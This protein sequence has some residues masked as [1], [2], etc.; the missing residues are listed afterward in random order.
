VLVVEPRPGYNHVVDLCDRAEPR[1]KIEAALNRWLGRPVVLRFL[2]PAGV[3]GPARTRHSATVARNDG[4]EDDPIVKLIVERF[5]A[6]LVRVDA[7]DE[8][9]PA[10]PS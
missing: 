6:R 8:P 9:S 10:D 7:E 3:E 4:L 2:R 1:S 5:E